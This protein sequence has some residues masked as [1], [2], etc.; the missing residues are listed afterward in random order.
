MLTSLLH[1]GG[2]ELKIFVVFLFA[3]GNSGRNKRGKSDRQAD[4]CG[5]G[6]HGCNQEPA[7]LARRGGRPI[8]QSASCG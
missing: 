2:G 3:S 4:G 7:D 6:E 1:C 8:C 5:D